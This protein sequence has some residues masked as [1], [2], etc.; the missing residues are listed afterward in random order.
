MKK[1]IYGYMVGLAALAIVLTITFSTFVYYDL[2]KKQVLT[3]LKEYSELLKLTDFYDSNKEFEYNSELYNLRLTV[4]KEDGT[5]I[6][7][8]DADTA[9]MENHLNRPEVMEAFKTGNGH[10]I[11][12]SETFKANTFYYAVRNDGRSGEKYVVRVSKEASSIFNVFAKSIPVLIVLSIGLFIWC[13][14]LAHF[15]TKSVLQPIKH[16]T[17]HLDDLEN[18][19]VYKELKPFVGAILKQHAEILKSANLRQEF[20]TNVSHE[21]KTP[22]ASISGYSELI[23]SGMATGSD[24]QKFAKEIHRNAKRL[25]TLINDIIR[26]SQLDSAAFK[27]NFTTVDLYEV[28]KECVEM[29]ALHAENMKVTLSLEG[30]AAL[31]QG[32]KS[33]LEEVIYNLC[34]NAIRYNKPGGTVKVRLSEEENQVY[35]VVEDNGI[36]I[37]EENQK[38]VFERFYRVDKSRSKQSGGTGLGLAIVKHIVMNHGANIRI[39]SEL[40]KGTKIMVVFEKEKDL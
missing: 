15:C 23:E 5:V 37:S 16:V 3:D 34:D 21:L 39:E 22:L 10:D 7:D 14:I 2:F 40:D 26:L 29:L 19:E 30:D 27:V 11:R 9:A 1:N 13:I 25:L 38:R 24:V 33:M 8:T 18:V 4:I 36:G 6:Y 35:L 12:Y 20:T 32:E 17:E 28:A 31:V